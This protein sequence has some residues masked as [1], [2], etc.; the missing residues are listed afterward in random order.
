MDRSSR[1]SCASSCV[2]P[3]ALFEHERFARAHSVSL[4]PR[5][6]P[7]LFHTNVQ[8][9]FSFPQTQDFNDCLKISHTKI[10]LAEPL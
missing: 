9:D 1:G 10:F 5:T 4:F 6:Y 8:A 7:D 2:L 3:V